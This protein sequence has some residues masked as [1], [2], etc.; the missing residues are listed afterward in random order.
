MS[1]TYGTFAEV[2]DFYLGFA[3]TVKLG[4][5]RNRLLRL[6]KASL[7]LRDLLGDVPNPE[8]GGGST[9]ITIDQLTEKFEEEGPI[10]LERLLSDLRDIGGR[11]GLRFY[12]KKTASSRELT[13]G[14]YDSVH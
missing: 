8:N 9:G 13:Y 14:S 12:L 3:D 11:I 7:I 2:S 6:S 5:Q 1:E 4:A 10:P